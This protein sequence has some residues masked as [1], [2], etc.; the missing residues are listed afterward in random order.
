[1]IGTRGVGGRV[2]EVVVRADNCMQQHVPDMENKGRDAMGNRVVRQVEYGKQLN[3]KEKNNKNEVT[4][5]R[6]T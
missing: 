5:A 1:M 4:C 6:V 2:V 3:E